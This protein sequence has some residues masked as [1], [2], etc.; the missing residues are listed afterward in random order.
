MSAHA[1]GPWQFD[2]VDGIIF[3]TTAAGQ[4]D[5]DIAEVAEAFD[6][7]SGEYEAN[8]YLIAAAPDLHASVV[9]LL[10]WLPDGVYASGARARADAALTK[11]RGPR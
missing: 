10:G 2:K 7:R 11:T 6:M 3:R 9:E 4:G 8:G 5:E 1:P